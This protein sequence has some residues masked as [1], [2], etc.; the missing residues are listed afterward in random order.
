MVINPKTR[1]VTFGVGQTKRSIQ[2]NNLNGCTNKVVVMIDTI[3]TG[4][5]G[6]IGNFRQ[7][8]VTDTL[9]VISQTYL[10]VYP[11]TLFIIHKSA[12]SLQMLSVTQAL[13]M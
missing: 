5:I 1:F 12:Q 4:D 2:A 11:T 13:E 10:L 9:H 8:N 6:A 7:K 3:T